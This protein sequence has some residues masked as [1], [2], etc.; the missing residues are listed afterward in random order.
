MSAGARALSGGLSKSPPSPT[1]TLM[2]PPGFRR[3]GPR[4]APPAWYTDRAGES[5]YLSVHKKGAP[6][7]APSVVLQPD[8]NAYGVV[9]CGVVAGSLG[10]AGVAGVAGS[11]GVAVG[12][13]ASNSV[14]LT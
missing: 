1:A 5:G 9:D 3:A 6:R 4:S 8:A 13:H 2:R 12:A 10:V 11:A 14:W 7:G